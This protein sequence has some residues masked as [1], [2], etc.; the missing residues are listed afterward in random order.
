MI[1]LHS[2]ILFGLDD[3]ASEL[4]ISIEMARI[5]IADGITHMACTPHVQE[6][7][8][9]NDCTTIRP[10]LQVLQQALHERS[11]PLALFCGAEAHL[12]WDL[13]QKLLSGEIPTI[14]DTRYFLLE[15]PHLVVPQR[16]HDFVLRLKDAGFI[17]IITHPERLTWTERRPDLLSK[18]SDFGCPL[19]VTADSFLGRFG[20]VAQEQAC[21]LVDAG[22]L[23]FVASDA[24]GPRSRAPRMSAAM[25]MVSSRWGEAAAQ[26]MFIEIPQIILSN[27]RLPDGPRQVPSP[28]RSMTSKNS[29]DRFLT[30]LRAGL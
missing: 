10:V 29:V 25:K 7:V 4:D 15:L 16:L 14:N 23:V 2:H 19:Q 6:G 26:R 24:H 27:G 3:G 5:A 18:I 13:P 30:L 12:A 9:A 8:Y 17:P 21:R 22:L 28:R 1:D 20:T 11:I